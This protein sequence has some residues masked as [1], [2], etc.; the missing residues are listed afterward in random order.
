[1]RIAQ[2]N[3]IQ[4]QI[5]LQSTNYKYSTKQKE[6]SQNTDTVTTITKPE[7]LKNHF[8]N[9]GAAKKIN[10]T[11]SNASK[12]KELEAM[13]SPQA[14]ELLSSARKIAKKYG[15]SAINQTIIL[16][17]S[18]IE[19]KEYIEELNNGDIDYSD[20]SG[21]DIP[22]AIINETT[23]NVFKD[24]EKRNTLSKSID[25]QIEFLTNA[26]ID[27]KPT[28]ITNTK[29][30]ISLTPDFIRDLT[31]KYNIEN[32]DEECT[33]GFIQDSTILSAALNTYNDKIQKN[34][35]TPFKMGIKEN[36]ILDKRPLKDRTLLS[37]Y[38]EKAKNIWD[39]LSYRTNIVILDDKETSPDYLINS[40]LDVFEKKDDSSKLNKK[41]TTI[42]NLNDTGYIDDFFIRKKFKEFEKNPEQ[43]YVVIMSI[44]D[45]T[46]ETLGL[47][48]YNEE[49]FNSAPDNVL[50]IMVADKDAYFKSYQD[51]DLKGFFDNFSDITIPLMTVQRTKVMFE[52]QPKLMKNIK[53]PFDKD[54]IEKCI[55]LTAALKGNYPEKAQKLMNEIALS[56]I[57]K[58]LITLKEID[59]FVQTHKDKFKSSDNQGSSIKIILDTKA[60]LK[61]IIGKDSALEDAKLIVDSVLEK[62]LGT[63]GYM[64][65]SQDGTDGAGRKFIAKAIAGEL[66]A[67]YIEANGIDF[68]T[69]NVDIFSLLAGDNKGASLSPEA[70]MKKLFGIVKSQ[71]ETTPNK[72]AVVLFENFAAFSGMFATEYSRKALSQLAREMEEAEEEGF[73]IVII[74]S[75]PDERYLED[76][77]LPS[78]K[79]LE[80]I[81]IDSPAFN[82]DIR[83]KLIENELKKQK[84]KL[85]EDS[86][87]QKL[88]ISQLVRTT[89][90]ASLTDIKLLIEKAKHVAKERKHD[91][92]EKGDFTEAYLRK[93]V[94]RVSGMNDPIYRKELVTSHECGHALNAY[95]MEELALEQNR[96]DHVGT[97]VNFITLDPRGIYGGA[98]YTS[99]M[100]NPEYS[101]EHVFSDII[102]DFGGTSAEQEFYGQ[103]GSWG[104]TS[105]MENA[106]KRATQAAGIMG[107]GRFFGKKSLNGMAFLSEKDQD[108][109]NKDIEVILKNAEA[110]SG[111]ITKIYEDFN[112]EFTKKYAPKVGTG[113]C[114]IQREDFIEFL[115]E[116]R[117]K[118]SEEKQ[119][120]F[121]DLKTAILDVIKAT[122]KGI[123]CYRES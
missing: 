23:D 30:K 67:P 112:K 104:I 91:F 68:C 98:V 108:L 22:N 12:M 35:V 31:S 48:Q 10:I 1:M 27:S 55:D 76:M 90:F 47:D 66:E 6:S 65:Y 64:I 69:E 102:C 49:I 105:D 17:A 43:N 28:K 103:N 116:W 60:K 86:K 117:S 106:T 4:K 15:Y 58:D 33:D 115:N 78:S 73:N 94:G 37:F 81:V 56:F 111:A 101:F 44:M 70:S 41:N 80:T 45:K 61:D 95:I 100:D 89:E 40:V 75:I 96:P 53:K 25:S 38:N 114:L 9:F 63:K 13:M 118:Q 59:E 19:I 74:G 7:A 77:K 109:I 32:S 93:S 120:E 121:A 83:R 123:I 52:E 99:G 50:F 26:V 29:T 82:S 24:K 34:I 113:E 92:V 42:V 21:Y 14:L 5:N 110:V 71:A 97:K 18:A 85:P 39:K 3:G 72:T 122:K 119:K 54:A 88:I 36:I 2:I 51:E 84:V 57:E 107:Q 8:L 79:F 11:A 20:N 46:L 16:L 87:E 62:N